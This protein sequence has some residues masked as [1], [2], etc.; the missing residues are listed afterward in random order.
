MEN[1]DPKKFSF[2]MFVHF[3]NMKPGQ[4]GDLRCG[5][6]ED[7]KQKHCEGKNLRGEDVIICMIEKAVFSEFHVI[8]SASSMH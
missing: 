1:V 2:M 4:I 5:I 7:L 8:G 3:P 6:C